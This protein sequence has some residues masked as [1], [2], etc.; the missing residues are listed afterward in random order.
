MKVQHL[1]KKITTS[2]YSTGIPQV[3]SVYIAFKMESFPTRM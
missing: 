1:D 3:S 2:K